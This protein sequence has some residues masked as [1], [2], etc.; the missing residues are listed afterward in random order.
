MNN[1]ELAIQFG[2]NIKIRRKSRGISQEKFSLLAELDRS[3]ISRVELGKVNISLQKAYYLA[4][5][6]ECDIQDLLPII[7]T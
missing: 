4:E 5:K 7:K 1:K 2:K 6:L 3:Y